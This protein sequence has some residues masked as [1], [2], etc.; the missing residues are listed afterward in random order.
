ME[1]K[2]AT[3]GIRQKKSPTKKKILKSIE[4]EYIAKKDVLDVIYKGDN[5]KSIYFAD[6]NVGIYICKGFV[7][8]STNFHRHIWSKI[9]G[10]GFDFSSIYL[11]Q[12]VDIANEH[13]E[14]ISD[15]NEKDELYYSI[16]KLSAINTLTASEKIIVRMTESF[17]YVVNSSVHAIGPE[18]FDDTNLSMQYISWCARNNLLLD[19]LTK[20]KTDDDFQGIFFNDLYHKYITSSRILS[21]N[22]EFKNPEELSKKIEEIEDKAYA[23]IKSYIEAN[24]GRMIDTIAIPKRKGSESEALNELQN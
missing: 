21:L 13:K 17:L 18:T 10:R 22:V 6:M 12:L 24:G 5:F 23:D 9:T 16:G 11:E 4:E 15:K 14:E 8:C 1:Q 19:S 3:N 20:A 2:K 7:V